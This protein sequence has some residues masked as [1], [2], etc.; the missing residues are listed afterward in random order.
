MGEPITCSLNVIVRYQE[1]DQMGVAHHSVYPI[2][3]EAGRTAFIREQGVPYGKL[4]EDGLYLP[5]ISMTCD[6]MSY[7]RY[8]DELT[9]K[10]VIASVTKTR[11]NFKYDVFKG[12]DIIASGGTAHIY[13][14]HQ[15]RPVN[16]AKY[17]PDAYRLFLGFAGADAPDL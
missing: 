2:W 6:F 11:L 7:A 10:T 14:N 15:L 5:L 12:G 8:E 16:L 13:A 1:T 4:E 17:M 9:V 3:F